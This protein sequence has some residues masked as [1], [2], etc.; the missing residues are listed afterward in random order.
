M[1]TYQVWLCHTSS[2][3]VQSWPR[4]CSTLASLKGLCSDS[5]Y[6]RGTS[7]EVWTLFR[8]TNLYF[9]VYVL[10]EGTCLYRGSLENLG[11]SPHASSSDH[12][13][14]LSPQ[15]IKEK[16]LYPWSSWDYG[17]RWWPA[18]GV[19]RVCLGRL[20]GSGK[21]PQKRGTGWTGRE[22]IPDK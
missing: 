8:A 7:G 5:L 22:G 2:F 6:L 14:Q 15:A 4:L 21:G 16:Q 10:R 9:Q 1:S 18:V 3:C 20:W 17:A 11:V 13:A 12:I 19:P